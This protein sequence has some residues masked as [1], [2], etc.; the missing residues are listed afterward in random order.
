[1]H[2]VSDGHS[3]PGL[4]HMYSPGN[5]EASLCVKCT[6]ALVSAGYTHTPVQLPHR[7]ASSV[8]CDV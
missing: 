4:N 8:K 3:D 6:L 2:V 7:P 5:V 1:M